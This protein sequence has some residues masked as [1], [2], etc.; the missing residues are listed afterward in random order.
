M[1]IDMAILSKDNILVMK[2]L[3]CEW[4]DL[5]STLRIVR[6][7]KQVAEIMAEVEYDV[8]KVNKIVFETIRKRNNWVER[9]KCPITAWNSFCL[10]GIM[11]MPAM[12]SENN[13][14]QR[15]KP[16]PQSNLPQ[17]M[18]DE[19]FRIMDA[20]IVL[21]TAAK[22]REKSQK[23]IIASFVAFYDY[24]KKQAPDR[25]ITQLTDF[26]EKDVLNFYDQLLR[27]KLSPLTGRQVSYNAL[28]KHIADLK[29][30]YK[31]GL[32]QR[33]LSNDILKDLKVHIHNTNKREFCLS[34]E[35]IEKLRTVNN[36]TCNK[37]SLIRQFEQ[38]RNNAMI[39]VQYE[40]A[41]RADDLVNLCWE[42]LPKYERSKTNVGPIIVR[43]AKARPE[44]HED[45][46]YILC[47]RLDS[48]LA[49]WKTISETYCRENSIIPQ[50]KII[51]GKVYHPIFFSAKGNMLGSETYISSIFSNQAEK[52]GIFLPSGY[53]SHII[54]HSRITHWIDDGYPF[55]KV[56]E[57]ARHSDLAMTWRYFHSNAQKRIEAVEKVEKL[58]K[59][60]RNIKV[61][62][63][64]P[65]GALRSMIQTI[66]GYIKNNR[67]TLNSEEIDSINLLEI[68]KHLAEGCVDYVESKAYY[69]FRDIIDKWGLGR[70]Q[71]YQRIKMLAKEGL[72]KPILDKNR[73]QRYSKEEIDYLTTL[74][75]SRKASVAFGYK[76]KVPTTIP[77]LANKGVIRST[78]IGKLHHFEPGELVEHF[79][80]K[81]CAH[82]STAAKN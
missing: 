15:V 50:E 21:S 36:T 54:R 8:T 5:N 25:A 16:L 70:T 43:G 51:S 31:M 62:L 4:A 27:T 18:A 12:F 53:K 46:I 2:G 28:T 60:S 20:H 61:S 11:K 63:L 74:V 71:T 26:V 39:S 10:Y 19:I 57:N 6:Y 7:K 65:K 1:T 80:D 29:R 81:N 14:I 9:Y 17:T 72:I 30:V 33:K 47:D 77:G 82:P 75:D 55:E 66:F 22:L 44:D 58:D 59:D 67:A 76:E 68:E 24:V 34:K 42:N 23:K 37:M 56:H 32:D 35:Q 38:I 40:G 48:D 13:L 52:A 64:P 41:L 78:K 73:K 45:R 49:K 69:T 3:L 79:Y